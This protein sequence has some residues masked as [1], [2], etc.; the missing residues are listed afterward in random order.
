MVPTLE[1]LE[2]RLTP[3]NVSASVTG[4]VLTISK[5]SG[6]DTINI[7]RDAFDNVNVS[8]TAGN[9]IN[10]SAGTFTSNAIIGMVIKL[11]TGK[12][13]V[14]IDG[15]TNGAINL[16]GGLSIF[17]TGGD[18]Q[19]SV[20][21]VNLGTLSCALAGA[22]AEVVVFTDVNVSGAATF[23][24][25]GVGNTTLVIAT[26]LNTLDHWGS[27]S[28]ANG[29]GSDSQTID[30]TTFAGNVTINNGPGAAGDTS[31]GG[32]GLT[33]FNAS[34]DPNLLTIGGNLSVSTS[35]GNAACLLNNYNIGGNVTINT[36]ADI[37][38]DTTQHGIIVE[39]AGSFSNS[40]TP[41]IG[42]NVSLT[43]AALPTSSLVLGI[44]LAG[45]ILVNGNVVIK[46]TGA[47]NVQVGLN[48]ASVPHGTTSVTVGPQAVVQVAIEPTIAPTVFGGLSISATGTQANEIEIGSI[49]N[50]NLTTSFN[51][52]LSLKLGSG[53]D[54]VSVGFS[55]GPVNIEGNLGISGSGG[56]KT[57][58]AQDMNLYG[59]G[60][61]NIALAGAGDEASTFVDVNVA[62]AATITHPGAGNT[63]VTIGTSGSPNTV[64]QWGSLSIING[65]GADSNLISD[66]NF[67]GN[68]TIKNGAGEAGNTSQGGGTITRLSTKNDHNLTT[69]EGNVSITTATGQA[70]NEIADANV[71]GNVTINTGAGISGQVTQQV[72][73][74]AVVQTVTAA[75]N[76]TIGG[77]VTITTSSLPGSGG[78][79]VVVGHDNVLLNIAGNLTIKGSG[80]GA[81]GVIL[82]DVSVPNGTT[83]IT[84][85]AQTT[86][87]TVYVYGTTF[88]SVF[89]TFT[90]TSAAASGSNILS[91][92]D[93]AGE[94]DFLGKVTVSLGTGND[95]LNVAA[96]AAHTFGVFK[97]VIRLFSSSSFNG[98]TGA[99]NQHYAGEIGVNL[100]FSSGPVFSHFT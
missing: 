24:H 23:T 49:I 60:K 75:G 50:K 58:I 61:L 37:V 51:G 17:G 77:N 74:I 87:N 94:T 63:N 84:L 79:F 7:V 1:R 99:T 83:S 54:N 80:T 35:T 20:R 68:V 57:I 38:G 93:Q 98:G 22:G 15:A 85:G 14:S 13:V 66:T 6:D 55:G 10:N 76:P 39:E 29:Q 3:T 47:G 16:P 8:T 40:G 59:T 82:H 2:D 81:V 11:G 28:V 19:V 53:N 100:L 67:A 5:F 27:L 30:D 88:N 41:V 36:G 44:G 72:V 71:V 48:N 92:Q 25:T 43:G 90:L 32:G 65:L 46:A 45:P 96:D 42:G 70:D 34:N 4:G 12:D 52:S 69:I 97:A 73:A 95:L 64:N 91:I 89:N 31:Q 56:N 33:L 62:G 86:G 18:K 26:N 78:A 21:A 9:T